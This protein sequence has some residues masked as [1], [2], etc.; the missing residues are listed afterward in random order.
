M[1]AN[2]GFKGLINLKP[3]IV[4]TQNRGGK[5]FPPSVWDQ[6]FLITSGILGAECTDFAQILEKIGRIFQVGQKIDLS[7]AQ[8]SSWSYS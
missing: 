4:N 5:Y 1:N 8:D 6:N 2:S 3:G 7:I